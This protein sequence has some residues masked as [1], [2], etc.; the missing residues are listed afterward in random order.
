MEKKQLKVDIIY[1]LKTGFEGLK[2]CVLKSNRNNP[3]KNKKMMEGCRAVEMQS[4]G[5][6]TDA[7]L[8]M[9]AGYELIDVK[10]GHTVTEAE[11]NDYLVIVD[12]N[13]RFHAWELARKENN[14]FEYLFQY[15]KYDDAQT[16]RNAY[17]KMNVCNTPTST[18]DFAR[19]LEATSNNPVIASY[20]SKTNE[21]LTSKASGYA[22]I[23]REITKK[24]MVELQKGIT[25]AL[26]NDKANQN[27]FENV[28][29][30]LTPIRKGSPLTFKGTEIWSWIANKIN[31]AEDKLIMSETIIKMFLTM[32]I[33]T[34]LSIQTAKK[35]GNRS[36]E[37]VVKDYL[38]KALQSMN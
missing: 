15:K 2:I 38:D 31:S 37:T 33:P 4:P 14:T 24:D 6:F 7:S 19:D 21:G 35:D 23:G 27:L 10:D 20:R 29:N 13:T 8:A 18:A 30:K 22:T 32:S 17:L 9:K 34:F 1:H 16:F 11:V 28:Y 12:G 36:K 26:F 3:I 5:I 25:P